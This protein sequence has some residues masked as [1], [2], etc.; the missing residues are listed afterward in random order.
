MSWFTGDGDSC[1]GPL[2]ATIAMT[3]MMTKNENDDDSQHC[4]DPVD[5]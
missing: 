4:Y 2:D 3:V 5:I 1:Y